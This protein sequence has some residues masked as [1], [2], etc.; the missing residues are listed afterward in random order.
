MPRSRAAL[1]Q[2]ARAAAYSGGIGICTCFQPL[3]L[4][5]PRLQLRDPTIHRQQHLNDRLTTRRV[6]RL[7][8]SALH[9]PYFDAAELCPPT[10]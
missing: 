9:T 1:R 4:L 2:R 3:E 5:D 7:R 6:D 8:L 10:N